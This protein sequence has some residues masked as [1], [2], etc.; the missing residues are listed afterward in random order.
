[1]WKSRGYNQLNL[2]EISSNENKHAVMF[3][4]IILGISNIK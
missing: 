3:S 1:M 4:N 2:P